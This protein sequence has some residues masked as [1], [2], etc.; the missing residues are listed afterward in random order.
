MGVRSLQ[1]PAPHVQENLRHLGFAGH[2]KGDKPGHCISHGKEMLI[3]Q[4]QSV[5]VL[6]SKPTGVPVETRWCNRLFNL[7]DFSYNYL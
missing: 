2:K 4:T 7:P 1:R 5:E 6:Q 3:K